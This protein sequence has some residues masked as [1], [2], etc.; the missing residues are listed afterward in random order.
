MERS[1]IGAARPACWLLA[2]APEDKAAR[3]ESKT[4]EE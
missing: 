1:S 3:T 2:L 4:V